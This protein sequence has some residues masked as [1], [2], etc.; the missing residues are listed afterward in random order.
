MIV[1]LTLSSSTFAQ[2]PVAKEVVV[3]TGSP[4]PVPLA[5]ADRSVSRFEIEPRRLL[6]NS[7]TD[8]LRLDSSLDLRARAPHGVQ[9]DLSIRGSTFGQTLVLF[10]GLR[11]N[12]AQSGHHHMNLPFP[13]ESLGAIEV[14]RGTGS[15]LYGA[16]AVGG[17]VQ[18]LPRRPE[19]PEFR[20]RGALG[21]F[22]ANQQ[23]L[24]AAW[25]GKRLT[26]QLAASRD[27]STGFIPNR[28]YR[29]LSLA[30]STWA[31]S[32]LGASSLVLA[33]NDRPFGAEQFYGNFNSWERT[34]AWFAGGRQAIGEKTQAA[35]GYRRHTDLFVLYRDRPQVFTNRHASESWQGTLRRREQ[36]R[37]GITLHFGGE[38][39][40]DS[41]VSNNLGRHN[42]ARA[43]GY[44]AFDARVLK[45]FSLNAGLRDELWGSANHQWTPS[46]SGG[47]WISA[48]WKLR[49]SISR[50]FR[51]PSY[52]DLYYQDPANRGTPDLRPERAWGTEAGVEYA[53]SEKLRVSTTVFQRRERDG[54]DY[55]RRTPADLW[56][57]ANI[58]QLHF[59]G[60]EAGLR[61][62]WFRQEFD[63]HY[64]GLRGTQA[65]L[66]GQFSKYV[67]N[68]P[69][70][71][72]VAGW[73]GAWRGWA[74]RVR[75]G[76]M[77]RLQRSPYA[78][79]DVYATRASGR[80][81]PFAQIT[82]LN[83]AVYQEIP[84]VATPGRGIL[85]G[86]ELVIR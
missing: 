20:I 7:F 27:F 25:A 45:R 57:A 35:F 68:Y 5:E 74:G 69:V 81:R 60:L 84:G 42:R 17:V 11:L 61:W 67:F 56:R 76:A 9:T 26:Q 52:T 66:A 6:L 83:A 38:G 8:L 31:Q 14:L 64:T 37:P 44:A 79:F 80:W 47:Y 85:G 43:A 82:N 3:V 71:S 50:A 55:V 28:D 63:F 32:K 16:D 36:L 22:G 86:V 58:Q 15:T 1:L 18:F 13:L 30:S 10:D 77:E 33:H 49:A 78:V 46:L 72:G 19:A 51:V 59:T 40:G 2:A 70:H 12:D 29:N 73:Q 62:R 34:K 23:R 39:H 48:Q 65:S 75:L 24:S 41:I 21:N 53:P 54:I 4:E